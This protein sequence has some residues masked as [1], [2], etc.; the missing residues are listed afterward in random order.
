MGSI[1]QRALAPRGAHSQRMGSS[2]AWI[3]PCFEWCHRSNG[4]PS[5]SFPGVLSLEAVHRGSVCP[6]HSCGE[7]QALRAA[8]PRSTHWQEHSHDS[9]LL[10]ANVPSPLEPQRKLPACNKSMYSAAAPYV[11]SPCLP[12]S[13]P[14]A[15]LLRNHIHTATTYYLWIRIDV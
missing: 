14:P 13:R 4:N 12:L 1:Q 11:H 10:A 15:A 9:V 5:R 2:T 6:A 8:R 7:Q 3:P